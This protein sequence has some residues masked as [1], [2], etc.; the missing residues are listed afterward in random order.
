MSALCNCLLRWKIYR[1]K[2][3]ILYMTNHAN[4]WPRSIGEQV[5]FYLI[6]IFPEGRTVAIA[7]VFLHSNPVIV[8][9]KQFTINRISVRRLTKPIDGYHSPQNLVKR[10]K[11]ALRFPAS[12]IV[13]FRRLMEC[14]KLRDSRGFTLS[15]S[16][17]PT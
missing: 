5:V 9:E 17:M 3:S 4:I 1:I 15:W 13:P 7:S 2:Y 10:F 11:V 6:A 8:R 16:T 12:D 14:V